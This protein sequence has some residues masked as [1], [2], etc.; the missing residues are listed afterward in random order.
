MSK[1]FSDIV[2]ADLEILGVEGL[3]P[4][5][6]GH[7]LKIEKDGKFNAINLDRMMV[8]TIADN[9]EVKIMGKLKP[10]WNE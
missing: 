5:I 6:Y 9:C 2:P 3:S 4:G 8:C 10:E 1:L 7:F